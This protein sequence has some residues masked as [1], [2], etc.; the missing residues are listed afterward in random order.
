LTSKVNAKPSTAMTPQAAQRIQSAT[1]KANG[2]IV[3]KSSFAARATSSAAKN[4]K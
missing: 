4:S 1:A 3:P 2:G